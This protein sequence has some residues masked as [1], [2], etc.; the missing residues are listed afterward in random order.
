MK[1]LPALFMIP[2]D[3]TLEKL[4]LSLCE[5]ILEKVESSQLQRDE[6]LDRGLLKE[7]PDSSEPGPGVTAAAAG[8]SGPRSRVRSVLR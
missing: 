2:S 5:E 8:R 1:T 4:R 6:T 7:E 3:E